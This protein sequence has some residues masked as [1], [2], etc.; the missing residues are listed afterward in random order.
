MTTPDLPD[1]DALRQLVEQIAGLHMPFGK[2]GPAEYPPKG[3]PVM[4]VPVEYLTWF[5]ERGFP[6]GKLGYLMEQCWLLRA[7]GLDRLFDP[8]RVRN[9][10]RAT[11]KP[12]RRTY[13]FGDD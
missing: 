4:D 8:F 1:A 5:K 7:N 13:E 11:R 6:K 3:Y 9:G 2:Y 12:K 10:G